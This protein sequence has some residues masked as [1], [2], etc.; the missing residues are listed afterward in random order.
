MQNKTKQK[1]KTSWRAGALGGVAGAS[2]V[3]RTKYGSSCRSCSVGLQM[4]LWLC[5]VICKKKYAWITDFLACC[6]NIS[7]Q[8]II[9][10]ITIIIH[11][12]IK[13]YLHMSGQAITDDLVCHQNRSM[14]HIIHITHTHTQRMGGTYVAMDKRSL[15]VCSCRTLSTNV[16]GT[17]STTPR[18]A[19]AGNRGNMHV[20]ACG[21]VHTV[22]DTRV[23]WSF[24]LSSPSLTSQ[25]FSTSCPGGLYFPSFSAVKGTWK[26]E[27]QC[28]GKF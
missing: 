4:C 2:W 11:I 5:T 14:Q 3:S 16:P 23:I 6:Q 9:I 21:W 22:G 17:L 27:K 25:S 28:M 20:C 8:H 7:I 1:R 18:V 12:I 15:W 10:I 13:I 24:T 19:S 26:K